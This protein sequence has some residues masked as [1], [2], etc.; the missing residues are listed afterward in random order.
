MLRNVFKLQERKWNM[1]FKPPKAH[2]ILQINTLGNW[3]YRITKLS[4]EIERHI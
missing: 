4:N 3:Y 1:C 2:N